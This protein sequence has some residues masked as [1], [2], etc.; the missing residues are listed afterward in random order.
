VSKFTDGLMRKIVAVAVA[1]CATLAVLSP[2]GAGVEQAAEQQTTQ[3]VNAAADR[4]VLT[5]FGW[6]PV[7]NFYRATAGLA[8]VKKNAPWSRGARLHSR[9]MAKNR[10]IGHDEN[11]SKRWYTSA[12][13]A[14][15]RNS[16]VTLTVGTPEPASARMLIERWMA[17]PFHAAGMIDGAMRRSGFGVYRAAM[18]GGRISEG[19]TL[20]VL[21]GRTGRAA[22]D[23][24]TWPAEG[25]QVPIATY[26][27]SEWPD[28]LTSC[29]KYRG[30]VGLPILALFPKD[31]RI[32]GSTFRSGS[33]E[34]DHCV[35][36][37]HSYRNKN[38]ADRDH[39]RAVLAG[40]NTVVLVPRAPLTDL[41]SYTASL[42]TSA[43]RTV[44][45]SFSVGEVEPPTNPRVDGAVTSRAFQE[46]KN[47][48][49]AWTA[50]DPDSGIA[51]YDVRWR[52]APVN[53]SLGPYSMWREGTSS[54]SS[55]FNASPGYTYCFSVRATDRAGNRSGWGQERCT[56][57][58][59]SARNLKAEPMWL[60]T[61][62]GDHYD[63]TALTQLAQGA[64]LS[65]G[66]VKARRI[67][68]IASRS[69]LGGVVDV[70]WNGK[71]LKRIELDAGSLRNRDQFDVVT[72]ARVRTGRVTIRVVSTDQPVIIEGLGVGRR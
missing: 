47:F 61:I 54:S 4:P 52:R 21:R 10:V 58:P 60:P 31:V 11:P 27:G 14:A 24:V 42:T 49:L 68:L 56:T 38:R 70:L 29:P 28:P 46:R 1:W 23:V 7:L 5:S 35:F 13:D 32:T 55:T 66:V 72:F 26:S 43:G 64:T 44:T 19:A 8:P 39:A 2:A 57:M 48:G 59:I 22:R 12:G 20:D 69:P 45:W 67:A 40:R 3:P 18:S 71:R 30:D 33:T 36:D 65:T 17:A 16:N 34:L 37:A 41:S 25:M 6:L 9:Y 63:G 53:G 15:A 62:A 51:T 50:D